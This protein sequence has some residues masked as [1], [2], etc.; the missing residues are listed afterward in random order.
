MKKVGIITMHR[1]QNNGS[2][3]QAFALQK[4][5]EN[6]GYTCEIIDYYYPNKYHEQI[7][8]GKS[9]LSYRRLSYI[10]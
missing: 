5:I 7:R 3:L 8:Y 10:I 6:F 9:V 2:V 4:K 1:V